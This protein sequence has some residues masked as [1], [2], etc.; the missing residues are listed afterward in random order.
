MSAPWGKLTGIRPGKIARKLLE[1]GLT[2]SQTK[3]V[4]LN[5]YQ[6]DD[7]RADLAVE[8]AEKEIK[9]I[10]NMFDNSISLY[11]GIPFC[12]SRCAYCSFISFSVEKSS[13]LMAPYIECLYKEISATAK[14]AKELGKTV[15]TIYIGGGTPT[16]LSADGLKYLIEHIFSSFDLS[17]IREFSVEAG[18][19]D[20][21]TK[22][23]I[24]AIKSS[25]ATRISINAQSMYDGVLKAIGRKH[26]VHDFENAFNTALSCGFD[27]INTDLIA[28]LPTESYD[29]FCRGL[30][31]V[32]KMGPKEITVHTM[33]LKRASNINQNIDDYDISDGDIAKQMMNF[34]ID[35]L[36]FSNFMPYYLY[37]QKNILG[38]LENIGFAKAGYECLY[39]IY[40]MEEV[41]SILAMGAGASTKLITSDDIHRIF[42]VKEPT[43][44][45][46][47]ID[48]M[49]QR[50]NIIKDII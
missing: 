21:I 12:P 29:M 28:G 16:T 11:I 14:I 26:T 13:S 9:F 3:E 18:R 48:E 36:R 2:S 27:N 47:R 10:D 40:I 43:E 42:N 46:N 32:I 39:N 33:S 30:E 50:K 44:Y 37:R 15:E 45:I 22:D 38:G 6:T 24:N 49:I 4:F 34:A 17:S 19:A 1:D 31:K 5:K 7:K 20:T 8:V 25:G 23:K 35:K 41:Q